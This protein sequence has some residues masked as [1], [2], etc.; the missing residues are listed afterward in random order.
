MIAN[1]LFKNFVTVET[2]YWALISFSYIFQPL[3]QMLALSWLG[4][5]SFN[6]F[7]YLAEYFNQNYYTRHNKVSFSFSF[8]ASMI[9]LL[10][11]LP[12]SMF[13]KYPRKRKF[14]FLLLISWLARAMITFLTCSYINFILLKCFQLQGFMGINFFFIWV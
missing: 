7:L 4:S 1:C 5:L 8:L 11:V 9:Y 10:T 13:S 2:L 6:A 12:N 3:T 14:F